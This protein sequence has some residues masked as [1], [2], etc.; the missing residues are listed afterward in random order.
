MSEI[1]RRLTPQA[2]SQPSLALLTWGKHPF[3]AW[4]FAWAESQERARPSNAESIQLPQG[5][6]FRCVRAG[7]FQPS[8]NQRRRWA[9]R[10]E[11]ARLHGIFCYAVK[12]LMFS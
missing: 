8:V 11:Q 12:R 7:L 2:L 6:A 9:Q 3:L 4:G 5:L 1:A 10:C